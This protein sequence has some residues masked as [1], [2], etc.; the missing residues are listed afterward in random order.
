MYQLAQAPF[1]SCWYASHGV[2]V[3]G[4]YH[5]EMLLCACIPCTMYTLQAKADLP[6]VAGVHIGLGQAV[7]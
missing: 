7:P 5:P 3:A 4:Q 2:A 6:H 1:V